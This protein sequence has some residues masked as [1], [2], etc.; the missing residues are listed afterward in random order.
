MPIALFCLVVAICQSL[1]QSNKASK[2]RKLDGLGLVTFAFVL[3]SFLLLVD[4]GGRDRDLNTPVISGLA[5]VFA[6]SAISFVLIEYHWA[7]QPI[8]PPSLVKQGG[9]WAYLAMQ[10]FLLCAQITVS[11]YRFVI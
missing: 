11:Q 5:V 2:K 4:F 6:V 9:V 1:P 8:I 10:V 3:S 7:T